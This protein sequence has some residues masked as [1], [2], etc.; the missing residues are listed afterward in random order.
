MAKN[1]V[2]FVTKYK[3]EVIFT[4]A[5]VLSIVL[6][7]MTFVLLGQYQA[8]L[9]DQASA[10][11]ILKTG[12]VLELVED[13]VKKQVANAEIAAELL[14]GE[15]YGSAKDFLNAWSRISGGSRFVY[16]N[17]VKF[18]C[19]NALYDGSGSVINSSAQETQ[20]L[21][22]QDTDKT[23]CVG[24]F[25][26]SAG[27]NPYVAIAAP[28]KNNQS[29]VTTVIFQLAP[30]FIINAADSCDRGAYEAMRLCSVCSKSGISLKNLI[31]DD[32]LDIHKNNDLFEK[33]DNLFWDKEVETDIK[34]ALV[35]GEKYSESVII[36]A[37]E[38]TVVCCGLGDELGAFGIIGV[39]KSADLYENGYDIINTILGAFAVMFLLLLF[40]SIYFIISSIITKHKV[41]SFEEVDMDFKCMTQTALEKVSDETLRKNP[42]TKFAFIFLEIRHFDFL[43]DNFD[44]ETNNLVLKYI[45]G[46]LKY[47]MLQGEC[48]CHVKNGDFIVFLHYKDKDALTDR[49]KKLV[50][51]LSNYKGK[52]PKNY[53]IEF[54]GGVYQ[55]ELD[56]TSDVVK[57]ISYAE[58]V[59][60]NK[61]VE[62]DFKNFRFYD[63]RLRDVEMVNDY[64]ELHMHDALEKKEFLVFYQPKLDIVTGKPEG[65]EALVR[66]FN[67]ETQQYMKPSLFMPLFEKNG[68][69]VNLD[70]FVFEETCKYISEA[71][72][73]GQKIFPVSVN[74]SGVTALSQGFAEAFISLKRKYNVNDG[75]IGMEFSPTFAN[76]N[77]ESLD[78]IV[79]KIRFN[80]I[81][82]AIDNFGTSPDT[83]M[84]L[85]R[86]S[87]DEIKLDASFIRVANAED[88]DDRVL[89]GII[90]IANQLKMKVTQQG[91]ETEDEIKRLKKLGCRV[92]QGFC[93]AKPMK[94]AEYIEFVDGKQ[95]EERYSTIM[96]GGD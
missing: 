11:A 37:I 41:G 6:A 1:K 59:L 70:K 72:L 74:V 52:L 42:G 79:R 84:I 12:E 63:D 10:N 18:F 45:V 58:N 36:D 60:D 75:M 33:L 56:Y 61:S 55:T 7:V 31:A 47:N 40:I 69:I 95:S 2:G 23:Y 68:F 94:L 51:V 14:S 15:S 20:L 39:A 54:A 35:S 86:L 91:V 77:F 21:A 19:G 8:G 32:I 87:L 89:S 92:V 76:A 16:F 83:F 81:R 71:T 82:C 62:P 80:G 17:S 64:I 44:A 3:T 43:T 66:W 90:N 65:A 29:V 53:K 49:L 28:I 67:S 48:F 57:M 5:A 78:Q 9:K 88:R 4:V 46:G 25:F 34:N 26:D 96:G 24:Y 22:A 13:S 50:S 30:D 38:H 85:R 93:Y 73:H 27:N